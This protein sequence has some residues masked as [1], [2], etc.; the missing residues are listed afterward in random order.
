MAVPFCPHGAPHAPGT[1]E[2]QPASPENKLNIVQQTYV[3]GIVHKSLLYNCTYF[4]QDY[5]Y[6]ACISVIARLIIYDS[7]YIAIS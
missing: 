1:H 6:T 2:D 3:V 7:D 4:N 5:A